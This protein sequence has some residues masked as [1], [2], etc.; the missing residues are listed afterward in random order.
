MWTTQDVSVYTVEL[1]RGRTD[2][3][4]CV[5]ASPF[6]F[7]LDCSWRRKLDCRSCIVKVGISP[8]DPQPESYQAYM[9]PV[10]SRWRFLLVFVDGQYSMY[11]EEGSG[12]LIFRNTVS[13]LYCASG[14]IESQ[15]PVGV[16]I[17]SIFD[18]IFM[19]TGTELTT[20]SMGHQ[21]SCSVSVLK[22]NVTQMRNSKFQGIGCNETLFRFTVMCIR[23]N[24]FSNQREFEVMGFR[25]N[26]YSMNRFSKFPRFRI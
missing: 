9:G 25:R 14:A 3:I 7:T 23:S 19:Q 11:L 21:Y 17:I 12:P 15:Q 24:G 5:C 1:T 16:E 10:E 26:E 4:L 20:L 8:M 18:K 2:C 22:S 13:K 6:A